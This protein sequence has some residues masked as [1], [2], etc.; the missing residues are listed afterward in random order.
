MAV[1]HY[2][3][4]ASNITARHQLQQDLADARLRTGLRVD[5]RQPTAKRTRACRW[6][7]AS[8]RCGWMP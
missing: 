8:Q 7:L 2:Q 5:E 6:A 4:E 1:M 3:L